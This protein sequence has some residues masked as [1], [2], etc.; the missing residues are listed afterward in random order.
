[1]STTTI[2]ATLLAALISVTGVAC[3]DRQDSPSSPTPGGGGSS[4]KQ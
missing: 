1:M 3:G 2:T 4:Q